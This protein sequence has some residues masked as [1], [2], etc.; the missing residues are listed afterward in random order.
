M[1]KKIKGCPK[2]KDILFIIAMSKMTRFEFERFFSIPKD[3]IYKFMKGSQQLPKKYW[4]IFLNPPPSLRAKIDAIDE[5]RYRARMRVNHRRVNGH[6][7][8]FDAKE[9]KERGRKV[10]KIGVLAKLLKN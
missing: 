2:K 10:K 1:L 3:T 6:V 8:R 4:H 5:T 9:K 7:S